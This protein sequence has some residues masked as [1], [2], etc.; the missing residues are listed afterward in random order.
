MSGSPEVIIGLVNPIGCANKA[1]FLSSLKKEMKARGYEMIEINITKELFE[2]VGDDVPK[3]LDIFLKMELLSKLRQLY[4]N[5]YMAA[6][7]I[8]KIT[9]ER[10]SYINKKRVYVIDQLKH[11]DESKLLNAVYGENYIQISC[12]SNKE[13]RNQVIE[14]LILRSGKCDCNEMDCEIKNYIK[15]L[16]AVKYCKLVS[17]I[18]SDELFKELKSG[19]REIQR[20]CSHQLLK[21][22]FIELYRN[23]EENGQQVAKLFDKSHYYINLDILKP[24][25]SK[26]VAKFAQHLFG[27]Y[28]GY[29][30]QDEFG[31]SIAYAASKR[32]NFP[33]ARHIGACIISEY[34]E[35]IAAGSIRA[36]NSDSNTTDDGMRSIEAGYCNFKSKIHDMREWLDNE[37]STK[38]KEVSEFLR[39]SLD[40]HPC[41]HAEIAAIM[42]AAKLGISVRNATLYST[43][44]PCHLCAKDIISAGIKKVV[45]IEPYP[46]SKN[47][48][49]YSKLIV[50]DALGE[51]RGMIPFNTFFGVGP[52]RYNY[53]YSLENRPK[54]ND[55]DS[56]CRD[57]PPLL[58]Y[59]TTK[60]Y[61]DIEQI[62][63]VG[64]LEGNKTDED[65]VFRDL[66]RKKQI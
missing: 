20:D 38:A 4:G 44:F 17:Y 35:V 26:Q 40:F 39:D 63:V 57:I 29:P 22:D 36:P 48:E 25:I 9:K 66:L 59:R 24:D 32:S 55:G 56:E 19:Y 50:I 41:T 65:F 62:V 2:K 31:M 12:F 15:K 5:A 14:K 64:Y 18:D 46:K 6:I 33:N 52:R 28:E 43:T 3:S 51:V 11:T 21:K 60:C 10:E 54:S 37:E 58:K 27:E 61:S 8:R 42:D 13:N 34:G 45:F 7:A 47:E 16:N 23:D 1:V 49:L 30:S 53:V